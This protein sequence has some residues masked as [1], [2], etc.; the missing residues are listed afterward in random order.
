MTWHD[1]LMS[2][3]RVE[4]LATGSLGRRLAAVDEVLRIV[5]LQTSMNSLSEL[6]LDTLRNIQ[7]VELG[8]K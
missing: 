2:T 6:E 5:A 4:S 7:P 8:I 1:E 3:C